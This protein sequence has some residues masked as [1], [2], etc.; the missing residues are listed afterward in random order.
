MIISR[1]V[2]VPQEPYSPEK[3]MTTQQRD[4]PSAEQ[5]KQERAQL[6]AA[7]GSRVIQMLGQPDD[8]HR[9]QVRQV[10]GD[11]YRVNVI[12]GADAVTAKVAHSFFLVVDGAGN[13]LASTPKITKHYELVE[14]AGPG[15]ALPPPP[16]SIP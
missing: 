4:K 13:I 11:R 6:D 14:S 5:A 12:T 9:L 10:W 16:L 2:R 7:I 3:Y 15:R 8:L 1:D